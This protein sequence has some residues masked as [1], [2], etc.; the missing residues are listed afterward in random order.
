MIM[1]VPKNKV[2][3]LSEFLAAK[4]Q[5]YNEIFTEEVIEKMKKFTKD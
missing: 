2:N 5:Y 4:N 3:L 1:E